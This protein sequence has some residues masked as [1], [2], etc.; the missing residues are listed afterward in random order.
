M[1]FLNFDY[2]GFLDLVYEK[3]LASV[4]IVHRL[5]LFFAVRMFN[6]FK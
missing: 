3:N 4:W 6:E 1:H 2:A 5:R